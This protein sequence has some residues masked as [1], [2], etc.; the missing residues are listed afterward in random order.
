M[1]TTPLFTDNEL[2][3]L[4]EVQTAKSGSAED[5]FIQE[6]IDL[7]RDWL[8]TRKLRNDPPPPDNQAILFVFAEAPLIDYGFDKKAVSN[9][10]QIRKKMGT[11]GQGIVVCNQNFRV[12]LKVRELLTVEDAY[13]FAESQLLA[14]HS[15]TIAKVG[16]HRLQIHRVGQRLVDWLDD[17]EE[18][19]INIDEIPLTPDVIADDL[20]RFHHT[21]LSTPLARAARHMWVRKDGRYYLGVQPEQHIQSFLLSHLDGLYS[22][23]AVFVREEIKNQGGRV[24][25][26]IDRP[27]Q[28]S[29]GKVNT[30]LELKVLKPSDSFKSNHDWARKGVEQA[31]GYRNHD[32]DTAFACL[33]DARRIKQD[34]PE[35]EP[36]AI[37]KNVRLERY[38]M[39]VPGDIKKQPDELPQA[40][41]PIQD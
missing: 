19:L 37:A 31:N 9:H 35:L 5:Q 29:S 14:S 39:D 7:V 12:M 15:F 10:Q 23:A 36:Y 3:M 18:V 28:G 17:P 38:L 34:M 20:I 30:I 32:T 33:F 13:A 40:P 24:D 2:S 16:Q 1:T 25:I 22:R 6:C 21:Y 11:L 41:E 8:S 27:R 4:S 26:W